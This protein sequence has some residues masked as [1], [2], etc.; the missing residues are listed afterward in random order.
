LNRDKLNC[1]TRVSESQPQ[2][3]TWSNQAEATKDSRSIN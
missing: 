2:R 3:R 1:V